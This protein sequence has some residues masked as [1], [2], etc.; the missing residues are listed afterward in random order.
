MDASIATITASIAFSRS[1]LLTIR[2]ATN[3][4]DLRVDATSPL[5]SY[6]GAHTQ[7][8]RSPGEEIPMRI[9]EESEPPR[10]TFGG[11]VHPVGMVASSDAELVA[12]ARAGDGAELGLL[13]ERHRASV[14]GGCAGCVG[15]LPG[16]RGRGPGGDRGRDRPAAGAPRTRAGGRLAA[17]DRPQQLPDRAQGAAPDGASRGAGAGL[18]RC[19]RV[20]RRACIASVGLPCARLAFGAAAVD[21][22]AP[23]FHRRDFV[24]GHRGVLGGANR[25]REE[26][27]G[28]G[29]GQARGDAPQVRGGPARRRS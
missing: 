25:D 29:E 4:L 2:A 6:D 18:R 11:R 19:G 12:F 16:G 21:A 26:P 13:I 28:R 3:E 17:H 10:R 22:V 8:Q 5:A 20:A 9:C 23:L 24:R 27:P 1:P 14:L 7:R 15:T